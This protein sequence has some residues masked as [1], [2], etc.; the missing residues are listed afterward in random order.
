MLTEL[1]STL[2]PF[3]IQDIERWINDDAAA[4]AVPG[5]IDRIV[6]FPFGGGGSCDIVGLHEDRSWPE[7]DIT[8]RGDGVD[9]HFSCVSA[10]LSSK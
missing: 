4:A 10:G 2:G 3:R 5:T 1:P 8:S 7:G 9:Q 6:G